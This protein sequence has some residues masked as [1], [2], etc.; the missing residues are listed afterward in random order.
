MCA[1]RILTRSALVLS[2]SPELFSILLAGEG[3]LCSRDRGK[4]VMTTTPSQTLHAVEASSRIQAAA[5]ARGFDWP[6]IGGVFAKVREELA[7]IEQARNAG[8]A[9][10][11]KRELGDLMFAIV[12]LARFLGADPAVELGRANERF[13]SR[14]TLLENELQREGR[15]V[16]QC[17][18]AELDAVW[19]RIKHTI[20]EPSTHE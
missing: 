5:S 18:L 8:N 7:E 4:N 14:F 2:S 16:E 6:D 9:E 15:V 13:L 1:E 19:D 17:T 20:P 10:H 11:A 12:N 3:A